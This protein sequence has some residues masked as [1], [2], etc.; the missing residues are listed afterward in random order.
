MRRVPL[1]VAFLLAVIPRLEAAI[2]ADARRILVDPDPYVG[3]A[4]TV[5]AKFVKFDARREPWEAQ[6]NLN[7]AGTIKF[8]V[9]RLGEIGCYAKNTR[10]TEAA[11]AGV[12]RGD[13][14]VL[15]GTLRRYRTKVVTRH[16]VSGGRRRGPRE[17]ERTVRGRVRYAFIVE[18]VRRAG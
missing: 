17:V 3:K 2:D 11:L 18:S 4:V 15:T 1:F 12:R 7:A 14:L 13:R 10:V 8:S 5:R 16:D 6:A 9:G